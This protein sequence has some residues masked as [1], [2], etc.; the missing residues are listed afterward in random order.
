MSPNAKSA[1]SM[2]SVTAELEDFDLD[3]IEVGIGSADPAVKWMTDGTGIYGPRR[4][5]IRPLRARAMKFPHRG[6]RYGGQIK[7]VGE[8]AYAEFVKGIVPHNYF[9][10]AQEATK[11]FVGAIFDRVGHDIAGVMA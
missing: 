3:H 10:N 5:V 7:I 11:H 2:H 1:R 6:V 4:S 8:Y 9:Q